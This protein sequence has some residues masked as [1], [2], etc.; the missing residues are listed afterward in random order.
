MR[1]ETIV[2]TKKEEQNLALF[3]KM[4]KG[5]KKEDMGGVRRVRRKNHILL[6]KPRKT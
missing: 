4:K 3:N 2:G 6:T 5:H 1:L